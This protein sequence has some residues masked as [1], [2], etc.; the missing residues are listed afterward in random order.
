VFDFIDDDSSDDIS[1]KEFVRF[2]NSGKGDKRF[3]VRGDHTELNVDD[4]YDID[5]MEAPK[6]TE[7]GME[8]HVWYAEQEHKKKVKHMDDITELVKKRLRAHS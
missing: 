3:P 5:H 6:L 1:A 8:S 4:F 2:L 7:S